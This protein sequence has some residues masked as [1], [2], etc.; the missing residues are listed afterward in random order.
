MLAQLSLLVLS[1]IAALLAALILPRDGV[2]IGASVASLLP[3]FFAIVLLTGFESAGGLQYVVDET[4]IADLGIHYR[5]GVDG[6]SLFL[7]VLTAAAWPVAMF[8]ASRGELEKPRMF[9]AMMA[10]AQ[11]ATLGAFAAQDLALFVLFFDFVL[12]PFYF[13]IGIWGGPGRVQATIKF[14]IYTLVGSLLMLAAAVAL[15]VLTGARNEL[16]GPVFAIQQL[17]ELQLDAGTQKWIFA[18]FAL[19]LLI[20][21]PAFPLHGWMPDT[22]RAAPLPVLIVFSAVVSKLGAYGF[23][24]VVLP[25]LP[26]GVAAFQDL[27]LVLALVSI[28]YGSVMAFTQNH[29]RLIVGYSSIAQLGFI[30]LG[31]FSLDPKGAEGAVVQMVSHGIVVVAL[32]LI[33]GYLAE[34]ADGERLDQMGGLASRAPVLA[35]L[36]LIVSLATLAMPG[37]VNFVG[38][39]Y[40]LFGAFDTQLVYGLI[41]TVGVALASVYM[42]RF[43]QRTM[44]NRGREDASREIGLAE[45]ALLVPVVVVLLAV[46]LY[47][48]Y[49]VKRI[50]PDAE[51]T[52]IGER[53][54]TTAK[55]GAGKLDYERDFGV[56]P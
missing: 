52:A 54:V 23:L 34:R 48:Q 46:S 21:M 17:S 28:V 16:D 38:E 39:M 32:F 24:R 33:I 26:E 19:A 37:S 22:Y 56:H 29:V 7:I 20:K 41:G 4:W 42:I 25:I 45:G 47:P 30:A 35:S 5:L 18:G 6:I 3:L 14:M 50:A 49:M 12:L 31:I 27:F 13:L 1:P 51:A 40:I 8:A 11:L 53:P 55:T 2:R 9:F 10:L 43:F 15:G 36:F 44:H